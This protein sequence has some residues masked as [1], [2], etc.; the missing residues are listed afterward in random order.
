MFL[1]NV[2]C[3]HFLS[4]INLPTQLFNS[5]QQFYRSIIPLYM[6]GQ[7]HG[8][9]QHD[10]YVSEDELINNNINIF[11]Y[12]LYSA[13]RINCI[14]MKCPLNQTHVTD[15]RIRIDVY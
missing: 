8:C 3:V 5:L 13:P 12:T 6:A 10:L 9:P 2:F 7:A 14:D 1:L 11:S 4:I 15:I